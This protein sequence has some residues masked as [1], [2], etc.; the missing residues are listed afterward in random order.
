ML[1]LFQS[2]PKP[3]GQAQFVYTPKN[4]QLVTSI[5]GA[6]NVVFNSAIDLSRFYEF[7]TKKNFQIRDGKVKIRDRKV[8]RNVIQANTRRR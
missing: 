7:A 6:D 1:R 3:D 5:E 8:K 2:F 4:R